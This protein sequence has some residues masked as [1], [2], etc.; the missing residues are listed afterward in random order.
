MKEQTTK[1]H[2]QSCKTEIVATA[3]DGKI[4][5]CYDTK[6]ELYSVEQVAP[7]TGDDR[8]KG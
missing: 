6:C 2:C 3:D 1:P 5:L 8:A 7:S 4:I